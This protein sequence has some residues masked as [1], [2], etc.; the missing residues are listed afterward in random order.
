MDYW[1]R[2][3]GRAFPKIARLDHETVSL[4]SDGHGNYY[5]WM[6]DVLPRLAALD[7]ESLPQRRFWSPRS[8]RS[9]ARRSTSCTF[10]AVP[11][12]LSIRANS[13]ARPS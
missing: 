5:H 7:L 11:A 9:T 8:F 13:T 12:R 4:V 1:M 2:K 10:R 3:R 6:L